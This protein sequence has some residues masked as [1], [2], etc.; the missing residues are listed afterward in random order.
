[1]L[2]FL[3]LFAVYMLLSQN[4]TYAE[5]K[6]T[7]SF[8]NTKRTRTLPSKPNIQNSNSQSTNL[9]KSQSQKAL[10]NSNPKFNSNSDKNLTLLKSEKQNN[11]NLSEKNVEDKLNSLKNKN[12]QF[13]AE[14]LHGHST[15]KKNK[16]ES[17]YTKF[18]TFDEKLKPF[19]HGVASGDPLTDRVI[20]WTRVTTDVD[21]DIE[22]DWIMATDKELKN[23]VKSGKVITNQ[24]KDYTVKID[25]SGLNSYT[26]YYYQFNA[27]GNKSIIGRTKTAP[28]KE[29]NVNKLRLAMIS[30]VNYQW[31]YFNA[32]ERIAERNDLDAVVHLGDYFYEYSDDYYK[33]PNLNNRKHLPASET[34][35][36]AEYRVR[37]SQY[38]LDPMLRKMHQQHPMI[39]TW[40]D[41]E[42]TNDSWMGGAE[43]HNPETEGDWNVRVQNSINAYDEWMPIRNVENKKNIYRSFK[44]GDLA[45]IIML[46]T[47]L[48]GR[49]EQLAPKGQSNGEVDTL[50]WQSPERTM[51]GQEQFSWLENTLKNSTAKWKLIG[52]SIMMVP[53]PPALITNMDA[54]DGYPAE[55]ERI[56]KLIADNNIKNVGILSG[57]FH[58]SFAS[59]ILSMLPENLAKYNPLTADGTSAF[60]FTTPSVSSANLNEQETLTLPGLGTIKPL[61][62]ELP[63]RSQVALLLE[64]Q[65]V[66]NVPWIGYMNS[67]Q[68]GYVLLDITQERTQAEWYLMED[69]LNI[70]NKENFAKAF[71]VNNS[72]NKLTENK[73]Q[74][75]K[76]INAAD[77]APWDTELSID[78][79]NSKNN[80][81]DLIVFGNYPNP[82]I[83]FT[84]FS[85]AIKKAGKVRINLYDMEGNLLDIIYDDYQEAG[86]HGIPYQTYNLT[87][88]TYFYSIL[89]NN[90]IISK[91]IVKVK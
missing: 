61:E 89:Y 29:D 42:T 49:Q 78:A 31:G 2:K 46:E 83:D 48:S 14:E 32:L 18:L 36:L 52:S 4:L 5:N 79:I 75:E 12:V 69:V 68:H 81:E 50:L 27:F 15:P 25:V 37:F 64:N 51:L 6:Q 80:T 19:Y 87:G 35:E 8:E 33:H 72:S 34:V 38:R 57:D 60:E 91:K 86:V 21:S 41:H 56:C 45:E 3:Y 24:S 74:T 66:S 58:M 11:K 70:N 26:T 43:N 39:A 1:M 77:L 85:Y 10:T 16:R 13:N 76:N 84:L 63:E 7:N 40:D 30:C 71:Y 88:G 82:V 90:N 59:N 28:K 20:I 17:S 65:V 9:D 23:V 73:I 44:Y 55:R 54:W 62:M 22:V 53:I 67:D 47:R